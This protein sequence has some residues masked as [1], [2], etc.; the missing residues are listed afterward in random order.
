V[1]AE[2]VAGANELASHW[3]PAVAARRTDQPPAGA[4]VAMNKYAR[5]SILPAILVAAA[6]LRFAAL[7]W[8]FPFS[9][10]CD[11]YG[12]IARVQRM[13]AE[14]SWDP[15]FYSYPALPEY[16][17]V[18]TALL[19][20]AAGAPLQQAE[21]YLFGRGMAAA[22][23]TATVALIYVA[24][25][26]AFGPGEAVFAALLLA[27]NVLHVRNSHFTSRDVPIGFWTAL[28]TLAAL[29]LLRR[30][31]WKAAVAAGAAGGLAAA[32]K[33]N[34][35]LALI[36]L[37]LAAALTSRPLSWRRRAGMTFAGGLVAVL[38]FL[39]AAP[40]TVLARDGFDAAFSYEFNYVRGIIRPEW[41]HEFDGTRPY[42]YHL[43]NNL[44]F[45]A[46]PL[47]ALAMLG[48]A[49]FAAIRHRR[50]DLVLLSFPLLY[51]AAIGGWH[52]KFMRYLLP[53]VPQLCLL[54]ALPLAWLWRAGQRGWSR[55]A[56]AAGQIAAMTVTVS[57]A[58]YALA[59]LNV[60][61]TPDARI[62]AVDW[63]RANLGA[64]HT[65][66]TEPS[67]WEQPQVGSSP[68]LIHRDRRYYKRTAYTVREMDMFRL[69][70]PGQSPAQL[71]AYVQERLAGVDA[72]IASERFFT[73][74]RNG[75]GDN[76]FIR[77]YYRRLF[78]GELGFRLEREIA[79]KPR[80]FGLDINDDNAEFN[81]RIFDH[82]RV[83]IFLRDGTKLNP[84]TP[85]LP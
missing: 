30:G 62:Q 48:G 18:S 84:P 67:P 51:F 7:D 2:E 37:P 77:E 27:F 65:V 76:P 46:G 73:V 13:T 52:I 41:S 22:F 36:M 55:P 11:E 58:L 74:H 38:V 34:G 32:T 9:L 23:G 33:Y 85:H 64:G 69:A 28:T 72:I 29:R 14:R 70:T 45:S 66:L 21:L 43:L 56:A 35:A 6:A 60:F 47:A 1:E 5:A 54:A 8:G 44:P 16:L 68:M 26:A 19:L 78:N 24:A 42:L 3:Q 59:Y 4:A 79:V 61:F 81:F 49:L 20:K 10:H 31:S 53:M 39:A 82:P 40:Y 80:L 63:A 17:M 83:W 57:A 50:E 12:M 71:E 75:Q 15:K 25:R